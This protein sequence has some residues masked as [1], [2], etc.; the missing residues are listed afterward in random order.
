M[1]I[2]RTHL[3]HPVVRIILVWLHFLNH[4]ATIEII[5]KEECIV[6]KRLCSYYTFSIL[7]DC[8]QSF[9]C[10]VEGHPFLFVPEGL[11]TAPYF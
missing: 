5:A 1:P 10:V 2:L 7:L 11:R 8:F 3:H 9:Y 4:A 6:P